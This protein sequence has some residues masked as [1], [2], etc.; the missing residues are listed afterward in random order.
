M[1]GN[2][3]NWRHQTSSCFLQ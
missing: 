2:I 3:F 1:D